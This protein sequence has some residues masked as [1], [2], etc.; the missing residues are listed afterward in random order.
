MTDTIPGTPFLSA[1]AL[2]RELE[3]WGPWLKPQVML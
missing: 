2:P 3:D 1:A